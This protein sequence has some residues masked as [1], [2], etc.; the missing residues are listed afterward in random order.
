MIN[1]KYVH[2]GLLAIV[3]YGISSVISR[4]IL[5]IESNLGL[6]IYTYYFII[7]FFTAFFLLAL[8]SIMYDGIQGVKNGVK[9]MGWLLIPAVAFSIFHGFITLYA[10]TIP[11]VNVGLVMEVKR[12]SIF[13]ET[14]IGG[15][16][17]H[18]HNLFLKLISSVVM[19]AGAY[20]IIS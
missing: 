9:N 15:E 3:C 17:F 14:L 19:I 4:Y 13:F 16:L 18:D 10:I 1:S 8:L 11:S 2:Y 20:L 7:K 6:N 12:V 5:N